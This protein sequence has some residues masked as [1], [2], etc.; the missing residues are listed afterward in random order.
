MPRAFT[1][2]ERARIRNRLIAAGKKI[3]NSAGI[4]LLV[5][6]DAARDAGIS[7]GSFYSFFPSREDFILSVFE[8]WESEYREALIREVT[9]EGGSARRK[10]ERFLRGSLKLL[11]REPGLAR[12]GFGDIQRLMEG[13][14]PERIASHQANDEKVIEKTFADWAHRGLVDPLALEAMPGIISALFTIAMHKDDFPPGSYEPAVKLIAEALSMRL[15]P[16]P[17]GGES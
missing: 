3:I 8:S 1:D 14:P 15:A 11:E 9:E 17:E 7:K 6:D 12:M 4:R 10:I 16:G 13:L 2:A 5:V